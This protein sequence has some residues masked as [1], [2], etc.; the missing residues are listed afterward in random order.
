MTN[1]SKKANLPEFRTELLEVQRRNEQ[2]T[3][4]K[5]AM[6]VLLDR[7]IVDIVAFG[8]YY[9]TPIPKAVV[10]AMKNADYT[11]TVFFLAPL[12]RDLYNTSNVCSYKESLEIHAFL[13][14]FYQAQGFKI[15]EIQ[16]D[17]IE[18][19]AKYLFAHLRRLVN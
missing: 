12:S 2:R 7:S 11:Q 9:R 1:L 10:K 5:N 13:T 18:N 4:T 6:L 15:V 19:R 3:S 16:A 14:G 8:D 17:T